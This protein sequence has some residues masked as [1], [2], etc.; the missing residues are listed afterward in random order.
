M[1]KTTFSL[2]KAFVSIE[3]NE[4]SA[5]SM[6][7]EQLALHIEAATTIQTL[8]ALVD[9][10]EGRFT[11]TQAAKGTLSSMA[12]I[13]HLLKRITF[14]N[15]RGHSSN[16]TRRGA[17][18][19]ECTKEEAQN[20]VKLSRYPARVVL[21]AYMIMGHPD[22]VFNGQDECEFALGES[23]ANFIREFELLIKIIIDGPIQT[24]QEEMAS[25]IPSE[26]TF[27]SQLEAFD[28]AWCSYLRCFVVW[29]CNDAKL[30]EKDLVR[31]AC[32]LELSMIQTWKLT[33]GDDGSLTYGLTHDMNTIQKQV[34]HL[35]YPERK[36][37]Q[38][39]SRTFP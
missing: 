24:S 16:A 5:K 26:K 32:Q 28:I 33:S 35:A 2:A 37:K 22:A 10:L 13:D 1:R 4:E 25:A 30:L 39:W 9:R 31:A 27:R 18:A 21:S 38:F 23:A 17:K 36:L 19:I 14:P 20:P 12:N 8:K 11:L 15:H 3:I 34:L 6:S 29:K 7:F